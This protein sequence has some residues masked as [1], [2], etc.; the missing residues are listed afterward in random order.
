VLR[1]SLKSA[2]MGAWLCKHYPPPIHSHHN[3]TS[4]DK[5]SIKQISQLTSYSQMLSLS[6][7]Q[8]G[9]EQTWRQNLTSHIE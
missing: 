1:L 9:P 3:K 2:S 6:P 4:K 5:M 8:S 7:T